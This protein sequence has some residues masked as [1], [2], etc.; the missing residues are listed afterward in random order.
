VSSGRRG[1][2]MGAQN[3]DSDRDVLALVRAWETRVQRGC[4]NAGVYL[5]VQTL[6]YGTG[7][8]TTECRP[9]T[10]GVMH[11]HAHALMPNGDTCER[12]VLKTFVGSGTVQMRFKPETLAFVEA[13][14]FRLSGACYTPCPP[15]LAFSPP[16][17]RL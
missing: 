3:A 15:L 9:T 13:S 10:H 14:E 5:D 16:C 6:Q 2:R 11:A 8:R 1:S 17:R 12:I 7:C 4:L